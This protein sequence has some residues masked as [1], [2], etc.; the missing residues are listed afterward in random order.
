MNPQVLHDYIIFPVCEAM[1][2]YSGDDYNTPAAR[3]LLLATFA[4]E[5]HCGEYLKQVRGPALGM[6]QMEPATIADL[7]KNFA[8][9]A[10]KELLYKFLSMAEIQYPGLIGMVGNLNYATALARMN[11]RRFPAALPMFGDQSAMWKYY[12]KYWNSVAG[13]AT[14]EDF[15][16]NWMRYV[17]AVD[18]SDPKERVKADTAVL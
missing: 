13:A 15:D 12:K 11:Y 18:F 8:T 5:S 10:R 9:G 1:K 17:K 16:T 14:K 6:P 7:Y 3:Q 4:Q 2:A